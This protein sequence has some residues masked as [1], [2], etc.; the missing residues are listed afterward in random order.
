MTLVSVSAFNDADLLDSCLASIR[1]HA[2]GAT[3]QVVDGRYVTHGE[4]PDNST[5]ATPDVAADY[6]ATYHP[7]G[8]YPTEKAKHEHRLSLSPRGTRCLFLD[9]DERLLA[10]DAG[11]IPDDT[12][13]RIRIFNAGMYGHTV[14]HYPRYFYPEQFDE[15]VRVDR[16]SFDAPVE[17]TD[18]ITVAHRP[19]L[20]PDSYRAAK[21]DRYDAEGRD[22]WYREHLEDLREN[23]VDADYTTCPECGET[24]LSRSRATTFGD[25]VTRVAAC[26]NGE[27]YAAIESVDVGEFVYLPDRVREGFETDVARVRLELAVAGWNVAQVWPVGGFERWVWNAVRFVEDEWD[28]E[29][30]I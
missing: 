9:A 29:R 2:P 26:V 10:F 16:F 4:P 22:N 6:D 28:G 7:G 12:V 27:C 19:D 1:E 17:R 13:G 15:V 14:R 8:P 11:A 30:V 18:G 5:D 25:A 23:G 21:V 3:T 20:R 24:S